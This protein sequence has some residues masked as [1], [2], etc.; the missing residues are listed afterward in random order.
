MKMKNKKLKKKEA[1]DDD[2]G[3]QPVGDIELVRS[4]VYYGRSG[5]G[6]T[7]LAATHPKPILLLDMKDKG[8]DSIS[9]VEGVF[10]KSITSREDLE[11]IYWHLHKNPKKFK[12]VVWDTASAFQQMVMEEI[13]EEGNKSLDKSFQKGGLT[14]QDFGKV[15]GY[16]KKWIINFRDLPLEVVFIAQDRTFNNDEDEGGVDVFDPEM[17]PAL[18]PSVAKVLNAAVMLIGNTY[19]KREVIK[20]EVDGKKKKSEKFKYGLRIGP[21]SVY[22]TKIR[23]NRSVELPDSIFNPT[24]KDILSTIKGEG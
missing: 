8:T 10:V 3:I 4:F 18:M 19:I 14:K 22:V 7:T 11:E 2:L 5:T 12:T 13:A 24:Y 16:M 6:K 1:N 17:G 15:S 20:K 9:D 21:N 23:K